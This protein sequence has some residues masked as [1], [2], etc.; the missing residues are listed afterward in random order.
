MGSMARGMV[1]GEDGAF[2]RMTERSNE[3]SSATFFKVSSSHKDWTAMG[4]ERSR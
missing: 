3:D 4:R 1:I 2:Y